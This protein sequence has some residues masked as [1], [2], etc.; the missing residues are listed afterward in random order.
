MMVSIQRSL[1]VPLVY[2]DA[3]ADANGSAD[4]IPPSP[5]NLCRTPTATPFFLILHQLG[6]L[7]PIAFLSI[8]SV[9]AFVSFFTVA[10]PLSLVVTN[11]FSHCSSLLFHTHWN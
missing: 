6:F 7:F 11:V 5:F 1:S 2:I 3:D 8:S 9:L 4:Y 10:R